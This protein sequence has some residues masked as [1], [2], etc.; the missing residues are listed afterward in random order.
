MVIEDLKV[1]LQASKS[2]QVL[3]GGVFLERIKEFLSTLKIPLPPKNEF[4]KIVGDA[5][6]TYIAPIDIP[7]VPNMIEPW[8]D[9]ALKAIILQQASRLYDQFAAA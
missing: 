2:N 1:E 3:A 8:V 5:Y 9:N 6:D 4:L 7:G